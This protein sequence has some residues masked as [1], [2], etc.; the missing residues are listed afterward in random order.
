MIPARFLPSSFSLRYSLPLLL[1][2]LSG[3]TLLAGE[4][5]PIRALLVTGGCCHEYGTQQKL[6][7]EGISAR[8]PVEW[9]VV[10]QGGST[11]DTKIPLYQKESWHEGYD[12]VVHNEC[13]AHVRDPEWTERIIR[14]HREGLPAVLI[15]CAMHSYRDRTDAWFRF[16]GVT[17]HRHGPH[18]PY[19]VVY[20]EPEHPVLVDLDPSFRVAQGELYH[21]EKVWPG[22][23]PLAHAARRGSDKKDVCVW[24]HTYG[25]GRV[26]GTTIGH[27]SST[28]RDPRYLDLVTRGL[29]WAVDGGDSKRI[30]SVK[31]PPVPVNLALGRRATASSEQDEARRAA[32]AVDG[33]PSTRWC[34][35]D[36]GTGHWW[37]VDLGESVPIRGVRIHWEFERAYRYRLEGSLDGKAWKTLVDRT[38]EDVKSPAGAHRFERQPARWIRITL[39]G[40]PDGAWAS[41]R[42]FEV[43]G[44]EML[45]AEKAR[46]IE[47]KQREKA[48]LEGVRAPEGFRV[49][50]F[51]TPPEVTFPAGLAA[52]P[53]GDVFVAIDKNSSISRDPGRGKI[54]RCRDEDGDGRADRITD[55]VEKI[56]SPRGLSFAGGKLY[57]VH[58]P[59]LSA[60][61]DTDDDGVSD[62][63]E[64]L[65]EGLGFDLSFRGADHTSNG[66][67]LGIDGWLYL[68]IGDYGMVDA[69]AR[70][71]SRLNLLGGGIV[72]VR[73]DGSDLEL[74]ADGLRNVYDIAV[75]PRLEAFTRD[76]TNDGGGWD[77]RFSHIT[78]TAR[79][80]YPMLFKNF[81]DEVAPP[82]AVHGGGSGTGA[83]AVSE[84]HFPAPYSD[85]VLTADWGRNHVYRHPLERA[86]ASF[87]PEQEEFLAIPRPT[88]LDVDARGGLYVAS[89]K[90]GMYTYTDKP[91]GFV[92]KLET[93]G[94]SRKPFPDL[95]QADAEGLIE[96]LLSASHVTRLAAQREL[97]QRE[98]G[99]EVSRALRDRIRQESLSME[100]RIALLHTLAQLEPRESRPFLTSLTTG[101]TELREHALRVLAD[102]V[103]PGE[104]V[105]LE[106]F[107][108]GLDS[109]EPR[110]MLQAIV[111]LGRLARIEAAG[112]LIPLVAHADPVLSHTAVQSLVKLR[113][114][115][116]CLEAASADDSPE[117]VWRGCLRVLNWLHDS[118]TVEGLIE[119]IEEASDPAR[120]Q[121]LITTLIRL[122]HT[123]KRWDGKGWWGTRPDTR[124]PYYRPIPWE[125]TDRIR[126][127]L[128]GLLERDGIEEHLGEIV[129][130][131]RRHRVDLPAYDALLVELAKQEAGLRSQAVELA[132]DMRQV[133]ATYLEILGTVVE[134]GEADPALRD[135]AILALGRVEGGQGL[136]RATRALTPEEPREDL[137]R[138]WREF[139]ADPARQGQIEFFRSRTL[140]DEV[141]V[142][143]LAYAVLL[144]LVERSRLNGKK[145][146]ELSQVLEEADGSP[147]RLVSLLGA[148][149]RLREKKLEKRVRGLLDHEL[150]DVRLAARVAAKRLGLAAPSDTG[151]RIGKIPAEKVLELVAKI[152]G[153]APSGR[154][155]FELQGCHK[156]HTV[157]PDQKPIGPYLGGISKRYSRVELARSILQPGATIAQGFSTSWFV[158]RDG[159]RL[160]GFVTRE[161]GNE[162]E[163]RDGE[164]QAITL[165]SADIIARG[166]Q[167]E[168][169]MPAGL[170]DDLSPAGLAD[171]LAYLESL[172]S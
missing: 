172:E 57:V 96:L 95:E 159:S 77:I 14:P 75:S 35:R 134:D 145:K 146:K 81:G 49:S 34:A 153:K 18:Y 85:M 13:F 66:V 37:Q 61:E 157:K 30:R 115:E 7:T 144:H 133:P 27:Y 51:A 39:T 154:G 70:D 5:K 148:I 36:A 78:A 122:H 108:R 87:R 68:A 53:G 102:R 22:V 129:S 52:S 160:Q 25:K 126:E 169:M 138:V 48:Q 109:G 12:V 132:A 4:E 54:V 86:G 149:G 56:D 55:F 23:T 166:T 42:E 99:P 84:P 170:V 80:G 164:G 6:L 38:G 43:H 72:R 40:Q 91:V 156:C 151:P 97:L 139:V 117:D 111:G 60:F 83:L 119:R 136:P 17:S 93:E 79:H 116:P 147:D 92:V 161:G 105:D 74:F 26:F 44:D 106:P 69:R 137:E 123:E 130:E 59:F 104:E 19:E 63:H 112:K 127:Y 73:P 50:L 118:K 65:V 15:H 110:T 11:T 94:A 125:Q 67:R 171:L 47:K 45:D 24:V 128:S 158:L 167:A 58:P 141:Q 150:E 90:G 124:G 33:D 152:P 113:A 168:S 142:R 163:I 10:H 107:Y 9:T 143:E 100:V 71:G 131:L 8:L 76:N 114:I 155:L 1:A 20:L 64:V 82:L 32:A 101:E 3:T 165:S 46:E 16:V 31:P 162:V 135:R 103:E 41:I 140:A 89:W 98:V 88:D 62:R 2:L 29:L 121:A 28:M 21:I 120:R